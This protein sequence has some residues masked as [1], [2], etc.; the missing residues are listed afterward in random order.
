MFEVSGETLVRKLEQYQ[1]EGKLRGLGFFLAGHPW[2]V[3][4][5]DGGTRTAFPHFG[6]YLL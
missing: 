5:H 3:V 2:A 6:L 1:I 4:D